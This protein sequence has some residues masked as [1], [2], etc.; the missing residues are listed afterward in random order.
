[1]SLLQQYILVSL[2]PA[3]FLLLLLNSLRLRKV[4]PRVF[5]YWFRKMRTDPEVGLT[6]CRFLVGGSIG[7]EEYLARLSAADSFNDFER[8]P[9]PELARAKADELVSR[10]SKA[11][12]LELSA[13]SQRKVLELVER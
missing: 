10:L 5:L 12:R 9:L 1:M 7:I 11:R 2:L 8:V 3:S 13:A 4:R 6:S